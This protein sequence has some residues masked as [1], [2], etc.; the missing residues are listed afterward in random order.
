MRERMPRNTREVQRG[1]AGQGAGERSSIAGLERGQDATGKVHV[2]IL[3]TAHAMQLERPPGLLD[4]PDHR[5]GLL[6]RR[7]RPGELRIVGPRPPEAH[8]RRYP[9]IALTRRRVG[10]RSEERRV[11]KECRSR[12]SP[13]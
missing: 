11:G 6:E 12:W 4:A 2:G 9:P 5:P 8:G 1:L 10:Y 7:G 13:Y 3:G